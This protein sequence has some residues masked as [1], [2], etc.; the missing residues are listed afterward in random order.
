MGRGSSKAGRGGRAG[1]VKDNSAAYTKNWSRTEALDQ[2]AIQ[3]QV[4]SYGAAINPVVVQ[5]NGHYNVAINAD[6]LRSA[7]QHGWEYVSLTKAENEYVRKKV[8]R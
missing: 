7:E 3:L 4:P 8:R 2:L 5:K 6:D 1:V